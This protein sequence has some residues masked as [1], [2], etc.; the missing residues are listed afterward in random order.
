[1]RT[2]SQL[3]LIGKELYKLTQKQSNR[4]IV[5]SAIDWIL[6]YDS[7][8]VSLEIS[9]KTIVLVR[10][11]AFCYDLNE[12][13][14][15]ENE[16]FTPGDL[17]SI[18]YLDFLNFV[19]RSKSLPTVHS[20]LLA[21]DIS[22]LKVVDEKGNIKVLDDN[23]DSTKIKFKLDRQAALRGEHLLLDLQELFPD[24][25]FTLELILEILFTDFIKEYPKGNIN[26]ILQKILSFKA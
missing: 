14:E 13:A 9:I 1:M 21:K 17:L 19:R 2:F 6:N 5:D 10:S 4:S 26:S 8:Y 25:H 20:W 18:L 11:Q 12:L 24:H 22:G 3:D 23:A 15:E 16:K 7:K